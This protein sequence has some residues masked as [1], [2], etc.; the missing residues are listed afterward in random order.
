MGLGF[1]AVHL[2]LLLGTFDVYDLEETEYGNV[3]VAMLDGHLDGYLHLA[4]DP[5]Q[6]DALASGAGRRRRTVWSIEP[7]VYPFFL[8]LGPSM[9]ALKLFALTGCALWAALWFGVGR[10]LAPSLP[11]WAVGI[12]FV[13]PMPLVQRAA[14][15]TT[16][17]TAHLGSSM[18][19]GACLLLALL[20]AERKGR[21][22]DL[23][24]L[25]LSGLVAGWGLHCSFSLAPLL[26]GVV[27]FVVL[28]RGAL[29]LVPW[30]LGTVPGLAT[31]WLFRDPSRANGDNDLVVS[32]TGLSAGTEGRA[33]GL[34]WQDLLTSLTH[35]A[36][37]GRV[38]AASL[39]L[40]YLPL[41]AAYTLLVVGIVVLG[42][43]LGRRAAS[44]A[45]PGSG[46]LLL[47]LAVSALA[48]L[49]SLLLTGFR[50]DTSYF[51]GLR[52]L[53][54]V[55][56]LPTL[57]VLWA[58]Q[59]SGRSRT[60]VAVVLGAHVLGFA[61]LFRPSVFPAPWHSMKGY[62]PWV[63]K[64][65]L[66]GELEPEEIHPDRLGR[67]AFWAGNSEARRLQ[68][69]DAPPTWAG[70]LERHQLQGDAALE[71]WRGFGFGLAVRQQMAEDG[72]FSPE[73]LP[74]AQRQALWQGAGMAQCYLP[75]EMRG[76]LL[77]RAP[78]GFAGD[79]WYG[80]A[81]ADIYCQRLPGG[82]PENDPVLGERVREGRRDGW[83]RDYSASGRPP[84]EEADLGF[85]V[86]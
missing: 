84:F 24:L 41:G 2:L 86:Y 31:A 21:G 23:P 26:L 57:A 17:I 50:L 58:A 38:D 28:A 60:F 71:F 45:S 34:P 78:E 27:L 67:W 19:H 6:G 79:L 4:T 25:A 75:D 18:W 8:A 20:A 44:P 10:R 56:S 66:Q 55:C 76:W 3:A 80:F 22:L 47:S 11:L 35:G 12:L 16:S 40:G 82:G 52:Y 5:E 61:L 62:E 33:D 70:Q 74:L 49:L 48:F 43:V 37:F 51:D 46:A 77:E 68:T 65:W 1:L 69:L 30:V 14:L 7:L 73:G 15:S 59:R 83:E 29:G 64:A 81:R 39:D 36:G 53:L 42:S 72:V 54:P 63:M 13:L 9:L 32:L 85:K